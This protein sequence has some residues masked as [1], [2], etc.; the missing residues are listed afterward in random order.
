M[1]CK[2]LPYTE[3]RC[4]CSLFSAPMYADL[5]LCLRPTVG[6]AQNVHMRHK[7]YIFEQQQLQWR[8]LSTSNC[9]WQWQI[10]NWAKTSS[11]PPPPPQFYCHPLSAQTNTVTKAAKMWTWKHLAL[12]YARVLML[13]SNLACTRIADTNT[14]FFVRQ[15]NMFFITAETLRRYICKTAIVELF[16]QKCD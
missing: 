14:K 9:A 6:I 8:K 15:A 10:W 12:N 7:P 16:R 11:R 4:E 1:Y 5:H 2:Y 3:W 13:R